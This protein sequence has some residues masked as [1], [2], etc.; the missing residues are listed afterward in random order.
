MKMNLKMKMKTALTTSFAA[1]AAVVFAASVDKAEFPE[2]SIEMTV[3]FGGSA[4]TIAQV[5]AELMSDELGQPV[6]AVSRTGGGGAIGYTY[7]RDTAPDGYNIVWNSN[8]ISTA[9]H[10]GNIDFNYETFE[11]VAL[12]SQEVPVIAVRTATEWTSLKDLVEW[13]NETGQR[14]RVGHAGVGSFTH[15]VSAALFQRLGLEVNFIP[16]GQGREV[17]E[18][19]AGRIDAAMRWPSEFIAHAETGELHIVCS[20]GA[21]RL[22]ALPDTPTCDEDGATGMSMSMWRGL[23][24]PAGTPGEVIAKLEAAAKAASE[25]EQF[26]ELAKNIGFTPAFTPADEFGKIIAADDEMISELVSELGLGN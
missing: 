20:T 1:A 26:H 8:S 11:P 7:V 4:L 6:V 12:V 18:L 17:A 5:L 3:L 9:H 15:L 14:L 10:F 16:Y 2:R 13:S 23:A 19:L 22:D 25:T 24:A 21:E